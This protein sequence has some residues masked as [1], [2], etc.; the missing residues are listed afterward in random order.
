MGLAL[1]VAVVAMAARAPL[2]APTPVNARSAQAPTTALFMV[3]LGTGVVMLGALVLVV[4]PGI[5]RFLHIP[6]YVA[7]G[8]MLLPT[9]EWVIRELT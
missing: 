7:P 6:G 5:C 9:L 8:T 3:L 1:A 4:W 2:S